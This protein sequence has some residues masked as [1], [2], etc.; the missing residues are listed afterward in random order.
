MDFDRDDDLGNE[1]EKIKKLKVFFC[2][3]VGGEENF[4]SLEKFNFAKYWTSWQIR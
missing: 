4:L 1:S 2:E 3:G